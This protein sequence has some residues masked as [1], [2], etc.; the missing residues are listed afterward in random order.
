MSTTDA[1]IYMLWAMATVGASLGLGYIAGRRRSRQADGAKNQLDIAKKVRSQ[2]QAVIAE[3]IGELQQDIQGTMLGLNNYM[4]K[5]LTQ[6]LQSEAKQYSASQTEVRKI[7]VDAV[8]ESKN[9]VLEQN[10][11]LKQH[12]QTSLTEV[13]QAALDAIAQAQA[14]LEQEKATLRAQMADELAKEKERRLT[15]F[16]TDMTDI[17]GYYVQVAV[18]NQLELRDQM[19]AILTDMKAAKAAM[20]EDLAHG[21]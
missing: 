2:A 14:Q 4:K 12:Y 3:Q 15:Q 20:L 16:E 1:V 7:A 21:A 18:G 10:A 9:L 5:E 8:T 17:V 11:E 6:T 19:P 13:R